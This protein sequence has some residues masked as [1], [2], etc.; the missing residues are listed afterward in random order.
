MGVT[1]SHSRLSAVTHHRIIYNSVPRP[2]GH[3]N[4]FPKD[5]TRVGPHYYKPQMPPSIPVFLCMDMQAR[6]QVLTFG[7]FLTP[8]AS[9]EE[10]G[11]VSLN[12]SV[13]Q[14]L[15]GVSH[16]CTLQPTCWCLLTNNGFSSHHE[17][18]VLFLFA[19][20]SKLFTSLHLTLCLCHSF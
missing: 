7:S 18:N 14:I 15:N 8:S 2:S 1:H 6:I 12:L 9:E 19:L 11:Y 16:K 17:K 13:R 5:N 10:R 4:G 3:M 20:L